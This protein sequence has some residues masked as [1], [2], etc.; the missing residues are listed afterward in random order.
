MSEVLEQLSDEDLKLL[1]QFIT[2]IEM[3][4]LKLELQQSRYRIVQLELKSKYN[5]KDQD[6]INTSTGIITRL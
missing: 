5:L 6:Q 4:S 1:R 3:L 2:D